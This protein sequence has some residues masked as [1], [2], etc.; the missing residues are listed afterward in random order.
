MPKKKI[1][2]LE[3]HED[4]VAFLKKRVLSENYKANVSK[5]EFDKTKSKYDRA[6]LKLKFMKS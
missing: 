1:N 5:E 2:E 6:K 3:A 4:Y